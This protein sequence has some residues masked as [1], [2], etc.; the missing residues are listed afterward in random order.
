[1]RHHLTILL[2]AMVTVTAMP[3]DRQPRAAEPLAVGGGSQ[4][5]IGEYLVAIGGCNDCHT[6]GWTRTP[7]AV[8]PAQ[9]LTGNPVGWH[10][11]GG[12][13]SPSICAC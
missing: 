2:C 11:P 7:G 3:S 12:P 9:R 4:I 10:G 8:P 5:A 6:V 13:A 1:M